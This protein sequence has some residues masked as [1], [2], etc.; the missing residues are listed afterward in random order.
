MGRIRKWI[1]VQ[2]WGQARENIPRGVEGEKEE[3][4]EKEEGEKKTKRVD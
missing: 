3:E 1:L 4:K 2:L